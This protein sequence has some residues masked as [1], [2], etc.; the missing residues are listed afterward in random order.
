[1]SVN[2]VYFL[3]FSAPF[4]KRAA[5]VNSNWA[6]AKKR[7]CRLAID[8]PTWALRYEPFERQS[9]GGLRAARKSSQGK[10]AELEYA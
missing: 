5:T 8:E 2:W 9:V 7:S 1:M 10:E 6:E 3:A 4:V